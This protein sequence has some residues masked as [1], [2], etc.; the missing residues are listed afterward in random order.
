MRDRKHLTDALDITPPF[1]RTKHGDAGALHNILCIRLCAHTITRRRNRDRLPQLALGTRASLPLFENVVRPPWIR[2]RRIPRI[3][4]AGGYLVRSLLLHLILSIQCIRLNEIFVGLIK[5]SD[6]LSLVTQPSLA[7]T[8][9]R[10]SPVP[11]S[12]DQAALSTESLNELNRL[13]FGRLSSKADIMLTQTTLNGT[14]CVRLAIGSVHT[15]E[16]HV[17]EAFALVSEEAKIALELWEQTFQGAA[18]V[19]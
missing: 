2:R 14:F 19:G 16:K 18:V 5:Q 13:F 3:H 17:H 8:V 1:L 4:P 10:V 7:L 9:F 15:T 12:S 6:T 11:E